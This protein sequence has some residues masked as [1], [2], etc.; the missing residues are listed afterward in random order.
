MLIPLLNFGGTNMVEYKYGEFTAVIDNTDADFVERFELAGEEYNENIKKIPVAGKESEKIR[1]VNRCVEK[2]FET[3]FGADAPKKLF[4]DS[5]S[6]QIRTDAFV[7]L[8]NVMRSDKS[9]VSNMQN[10]VRAWGGNREQR[11]RNKKHKSGDF[12][13]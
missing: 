5:Q 7:E 9:A 13:K 4:G 8:I 3:L 11:R 2:V 1:Y 10:A 6:G 12:I